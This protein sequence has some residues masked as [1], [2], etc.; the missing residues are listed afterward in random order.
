MAGPVRRLARHAARLSG[1]AAMVSDPGRRAFT[2]ASIGAALA[3]L[4]GGPAWAENVAAL[5][6]VD[7]ELRAAAAALIARPIGPLCDARLA[8]LRAGA[9]ARAEPPR[10]DVPIAE[11][12]IPGARGAPDVTIFIVNAA[13]GTA[14]PAILHMHGGGFVLGAARSE[15]R[16]VQEIARA[17]DAV[18]VSVEYRLAPETRFAG[19]VEDNYA[20]L[21]WLYRHA[22]AIGAD[23]RRIAVMGES[24]GGGHAALLAIAA[25]DRGEVPLVLQLLLYPM[26]D[27]RT[28]ST[29]RPAPHIGTILWDG[30]ANAYGWRSYLGVEPGGADVP[31]AAVPARLADM[32]GLA[33]AFIAI[34]GIDLFVDEAITYA[35]R[36]NAAGVATELLVQ[37]GAFHA[38]DRLAPETRAAR[39]FSAAKL[40]A[41]RRAFVQPDPG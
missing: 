34:G 35:R 15:L 1:R 32:S 23:P 3:A 39:R 26:L 8:A 13:P 24:A 20:A 11:R 25:R 10:P 28:G 22:G 27:D 19:A 5:A 9:R 38:F 7:P 33:P 18:V 17:I 37:P 14:R 2:G 16:Y 40:A 31:A 29:R 30:A 21:R 4:F 6:H 12:R 41:L 36:L